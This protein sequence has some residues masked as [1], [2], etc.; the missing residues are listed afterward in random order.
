MTDSRSV[1]P[2][3]QSQDFINTLPHSLKTHVSDN[4]GDVEQLKGEMAYLQRQYELEEQLIQIKEQQ[5]EREEQQKMR[6]I[7]QQLKLLNLQNKIAAAAATPDTAVAADATA[8]TTPDAAAASAA[9]SNT[10]AAAAA[11]AAAASANTATLPT[12]LHPQP[13]KDWL[14]SAATANSIA[15][16]SIHQPKQGMPNNNI[17]IQTA[18]ITNGATILPAQQ[19]LRESMHNKNNSTDI[20]Y[21]PSPCPPMETRPGN[22]ISQAA[23][24]REPRYSH[25]S[26]QSSVDITERLIDAIQAPKAI[27]PK[28][29]GDP[30]HYH[31]FI[32]AFQNN[33]E[34]KLTD[35]TARLTRLV[36]H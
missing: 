15:M 26:T 33:V 36:Q 19:Q 31:K 25:P 8:T 21:F 11:A 10:A 23:I 5:R 28:F 2:L 29:S 4:N 3:S 6:A 30:V 13:V 35:P 16:P 27:I 22:I 34:S 1:S 17:N 24:H 12:P 14:Q 9:I 32:S 18:D 7:Q 20:G